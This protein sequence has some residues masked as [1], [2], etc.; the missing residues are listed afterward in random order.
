MSAAFAGGCLAFE[1]LLP[2]VL[3]LG[4]SHADEEREQGGALPGRVVDALEGAGSSSFGERGKAPKGP[5]ED[6]QGAGALEVGATGTL[7]RVVDVPV[8]CGG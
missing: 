6:G 4:L 1:G 5:C 7:E 3:A 2:D 8:G